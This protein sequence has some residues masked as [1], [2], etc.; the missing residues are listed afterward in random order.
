MRGTNLLTDKAIKSVKPGHGKAQLTDGRGLY[1]K[2]FADRGQHSWRFDYRSVE[3]KRQTL[4]IGPYPTIT[5]AKAREVA[6]EAREGLVLGRN[7]VSPRQAAR[8]E[9]VEAQVE[10]GAD[11]CLRVTA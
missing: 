11:P 4:I 9:A 7:P 2:L 3:G 8:V 6:Q 1:L 5:L 10:L